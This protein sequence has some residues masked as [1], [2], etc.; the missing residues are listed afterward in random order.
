MINPRDL[1]V[2]VSFFHLQTEH[3]TIFILLQHSKM[4]CYGPISEMS[5][6]KNIFF[7]LFGAIPIVF[8][9]S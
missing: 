7:I 9:Y 3:I 1:Q 2:I 8:D 6:S 4:L 5:L